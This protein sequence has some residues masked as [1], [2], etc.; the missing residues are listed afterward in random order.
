MGQKGGIL[1]Y[2]F[3]E[4]RLKNFTNIRKKTLAIL[5]EVCYNVLTKNRFWRMLSKNGVF[6]TVFGAKRGAKSGFERRKP[7]NLVF[8][9][10]R[11]NKLLFA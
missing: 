8:T 3:H 2:I 9:R 6:G 10:K 1:L 7:Q 11:G 4:K 5:H